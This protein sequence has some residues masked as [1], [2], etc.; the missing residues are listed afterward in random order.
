MDNF[1]LLAKV[2][3]NYNGKPKTDKPRRRDGHS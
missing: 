1:E 3:R 2:E